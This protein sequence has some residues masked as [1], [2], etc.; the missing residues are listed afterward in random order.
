MTN[1]TRLG[2]ISEKRGDTL[3]GTIERTYKVDLGYRSDAKLETVLK[4]MGAPSL[5]KLV[6]MVRATRERQGK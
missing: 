3:V 5:S 6:K 1:R 2:R 4:D